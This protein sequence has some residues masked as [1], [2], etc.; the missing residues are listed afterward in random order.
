MSNLGST[1]PLR[2]QSDK[3]LIEDVRDELMIYD[4]ERNK[5]F[6]LNP[7]AAFVWKHADGKTSAAAI[8]HRMERELGK[9]VDEEVVS[10]ALD[11]LAK[12]GLLASEAALPTTVDVSR[13]NALQKIGIGAIALPVVTALFV[14]P[15]KAHASG[16]NVPPPEET[17]TQENHPGGGFWA[18]L[19]RLF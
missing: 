19:E 16:V 7:T 10:F 4:T 6:C 8:A 13:R 11:V 14:S 18:W 1:L 2:L 17:I 9:P 3:L 15:A 5:A 12:D